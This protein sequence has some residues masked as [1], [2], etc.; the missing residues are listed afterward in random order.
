MDEDEIGHMLLESDETGES[1]LYSVDN[2]ANN[3]A[4]EASTASSSIITLSQKRKL[5]LAG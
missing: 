4:T 2:V 5:R 3:D 1:M